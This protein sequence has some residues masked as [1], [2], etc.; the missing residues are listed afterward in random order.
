M[1]VF[2]AARIIILC[3]LIFI[4]PLAYTY[5]KLYLSSMSITAFGYIEPS[6]GALASLLAIAVNTVGI[7]VLGILLTLLL[8]VLLPRRSLAPSV[9]IAL[10]IVVWSSIHWIM[11]TDSPSY[12]TVVEWLTIL[13]VIPLIAVLSDRFFSNKEK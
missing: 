1:K 6:T 2:E 13:I 5:Y 12:I 10:T 7:F 3:G 4:A 8:N 9:V 11:C